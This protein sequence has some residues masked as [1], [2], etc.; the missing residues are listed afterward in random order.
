[1]AQHRTDGGVRYSAARSE[2]G[3]ALASLLAGIL[4]I[5][6]GVGI[7]EAIL[8]AGLTAIGVDESAAF[9]IAVT[10][11]V[12]SAYLPPVWGWLSLQWLQRN[13]YL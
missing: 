10:Y 11:R 6:G 2:E 9:G 1:V 4:P 3:P 5:P 13:D 8:T 7:T 12:I